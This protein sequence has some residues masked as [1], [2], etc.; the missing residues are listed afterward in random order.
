[1][2]RGRKQWHG[3]DE[4]ARARACQSLCPS[5]D[6]PVACDLTLDE[7][8]RVAHGEESRLP[9]RHSALGQ[10]EPLGVCLWRS[11]GAGVGRSRRY[12]LRWSDTGALM[13]RIRCS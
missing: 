7:V 2:S 3:S 6:A 11:S 5:R 9:K 12:A 4:P 1:V 8:A 13:L 10:T